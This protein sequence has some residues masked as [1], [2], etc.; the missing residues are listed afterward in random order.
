[1]LKGWKARKPNYFLVVFGEKY[2]A[3]HPVEDG[4]YPHHKGY[5]NGSGVAAGDVL[6]LFQNLGALGV[7]VV[8]G[9]ETGGEAEEIDYQFFPLDPAV[10]WD[11]LD[12]LQNTIPGLRIPLHYRGNLLQKISNTSFQRALA[13]TQIKWP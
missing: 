10:A 9:A 8:I 11:S 13:G 6:L 2:A 7:G 3:K 5:I 1:M 4:V 12:T